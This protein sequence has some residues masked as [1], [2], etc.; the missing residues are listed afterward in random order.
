MIQSAGVAEARGG[1]L[2][3][4]Q[5]L[6]K[7]LPRFSLA[8]LMIVIACCAIGLTIGTS[9]VDEPDG[10]AASFGFY[11]PQL[12]WHYAFLATA[13]CFLI[14][15]LWRQQRQLSRR[16]PTDVGGANRAG[17]KWAILSRRLLIFILASSLGFVFLLQQRMIKFA[18]PEEHLYVLTDE[19]FPQTLWYITFLVALVVAAPFPDRIPHSKVRS[20]VDIL[21]G[22]VCGVWL[23]VYLVSDYFFIMYLVHVATAGI[24]AGR[25]LRLQRLEHFPNHHREGWFTFSAS[26]AALITF[27]VATICFVALCRLSVSRGKR[28]AI[29]SVF[30]LA[31]GIGGAFTFWFFG[32]ELHRVSPDIAPQIARAAMLR[33]WLG[34][35]LL[36]SVVSVVA[37][38][39]VTRDEVLPV[40]IVDPIRASGMALIAI[41]PGLIS[42]ILLLFES[43]RAVLSPGPFG[44]TSASELLWYLLSSPFLLL[45]LSTGILAMQIAWRW[46]RRGAPEIVILP[47]EPQ[48]VLWAW[49]GLTALVILGVPVLAA[50]GF[51]WWLGPWYLR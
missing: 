40:C 48:R 47:I 34:A 23:V 11:E 30:V 28:F 16:I 33:D 17:W 37:A 27:L 19:I 2:S 43:L 4:L 20:V 50:F 7:R 8:S 29:I 41:F 5:Y 21:A 45:Q 9:P 46:W 15:E 22:W 25:P 26:S 14:V 1:R 31:I 6:S 3:K 24:D 42:L 10:M 44:G 32:K 35:A 13:S 18:E 38:I 36:F 12:N 51:S 49:L 39:R